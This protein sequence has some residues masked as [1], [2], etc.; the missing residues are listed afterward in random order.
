MRPGLS[1]NLRLTDLA[2]VSGHKVLRIFSVFSAGISR[3]HYTHISKCGLSQTS[4]QACK[5]STLPPSYLPRPQK[6]GRLWDIEAGNKES[7]VGDAGVKGMQA[8]EDLEPPAAR[9]QLE[10]TLPQSPGGIGECKLPITG[11]WIWLW[12]E[13]SLSLWPPE[14]W[15]AW[16]IFLSHQE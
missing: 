10:W 9:R 14:L 4:S 11:L 15:D 16:S 7:T 5:A 6:L 1:L 13:T 8:K 3:T 12:G 2:K